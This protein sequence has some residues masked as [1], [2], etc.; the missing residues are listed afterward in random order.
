MPT[1]MTRNFW[2]NARDISQVLSQA[3]H[4]GHLLG[5][6]HTGLYVVYR[7]EDIPFGFREEQNHQTAA[8][9]ILQVL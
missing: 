5:R 2:G 8:F 6:F 1:G 3:Y 4:L 9:K 7:A